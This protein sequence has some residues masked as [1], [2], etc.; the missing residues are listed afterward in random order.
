MKQI[1]IGNL[2]YRKSYEKDVLFRVADIIFD[3]G[4]KIIILKGVN[5]R[6]QA[7]AEEEDL[8]IIEYDKNKISGNIL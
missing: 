4:K 1:E 7:D 5:V 6:L 8:D 2:V 3:H